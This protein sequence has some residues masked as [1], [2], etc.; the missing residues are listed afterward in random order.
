M[1][2]VG[3]SVERRAP[4][5]PRHRPTFVFAILLELLAAMG[6]D[7]GSAQTLVDAAA[8]DA[9]V[10]QLHRAASDTN[11]CKDPPPPGDPVQGYASPCYKDS[12]CDSGL[13]PRCYG[14]SFVVGSSVVADNACV[15]DSCIADSDCG[16]GG[17]CDCRDPIWD[18]A[19]VCF[20][21]NCRTDSDCGPFG[22]CSPSGLESC[23]VGFYPSLIANCL[24][25]GAGFYC[26]TPADR[27]VDDSDCSDAG[28]IPCAF[29]AKARAWQCNG[30][31]GD[32]SL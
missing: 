16:D 4:G 22:Y 30:G 8:V 10:P 6:C 1:S 11:A 23:R 29:N 24:C 18:N 25:E 20:T 31:C 5:G 3:P 26:H 19:N 2:C 21:G 7:Q 12:D 32:A 28:T 14:R 13:N 27:C 15:S 17:V 9:R